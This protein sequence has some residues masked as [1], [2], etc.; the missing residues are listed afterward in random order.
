MARAGK[1]ARVSSLDWFLVHE[2]GQDKQ[3]C[4]SEGLLQF[5]SIRSCFHCL[6]VLRLLLLFR[7]KWLRSKLR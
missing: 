6:V 1:G 4:V 3:W 5:N 2:S 7:T